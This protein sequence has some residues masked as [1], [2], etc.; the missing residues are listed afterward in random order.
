MNSQFDSIIYRKDWELL[1]DEVQRN[2]VVKK[3]KKMTW[4]R[5]NFKNSKGEVIRTYIYGRNFKRGKK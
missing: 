4:I 5:L 3:G 2:L 1:P